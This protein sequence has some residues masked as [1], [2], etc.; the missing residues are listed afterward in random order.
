MAIKVEP[1]KKLFKFQ[2]LGPSVNLMSATLGRSEKY[3]QTI[4]RKFQWYA[5]FFILLL[6][7]YRQLVGNMSFLKYS[8]KYLPLLG[9]QMGR[10]AGLLW[11]FFNRTIKRYGSRTSGLSHDLSNSS[12]FFLY[13]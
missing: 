5:H 7:L 3:W 6:F 9:I 10:P 12:L 1:I 2:D 11:D 4:F 13:S 8:I